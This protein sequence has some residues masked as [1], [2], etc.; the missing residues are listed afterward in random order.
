MKQEHG[1]YE[2]ADGNIVEFFKTSRWMLTYIE[3]VY[4]VH[5]LESDVSFEVPD[6]DAGL[7]EIGWVL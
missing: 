1:T 3:G 2:S 6:V 5:G 7:K 4:T